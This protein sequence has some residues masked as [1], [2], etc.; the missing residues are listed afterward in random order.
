MENPNWGTITEAAEYFGLTRQRI[1][2]LIVKGMMGDCRKVSMMG[3]P[4]RGEIWLIKKPFRRM[5]A[6]PFSNVRQ[7]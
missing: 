7:S 4:Y 2:Q 3:A 1:H 6:L 5:A